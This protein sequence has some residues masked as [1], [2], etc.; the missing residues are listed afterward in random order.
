VLRGKVVVSSSKFV[1]MVLSE[2]SICKLNFLGTQNSIG[3]KLTEEV[4]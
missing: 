1:Y 2:N 4:Y 3:L